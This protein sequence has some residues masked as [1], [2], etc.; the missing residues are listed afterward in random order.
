MRLTVNAESRELPD[1]ATVAALLASLALPSTRVAVEVNR[2]LVRRLQHGE[3]VLHDG[4][5][6]EVVTLVG[7]G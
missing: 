5:V 7:G 6:I 2:Q 1:G 4:D 3:H